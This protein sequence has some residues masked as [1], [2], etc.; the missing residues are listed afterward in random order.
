MAF[1]RLIAGAIVT[2]A[3]A[4][5]LSEPSARATTVFIDSA[6]SGCDQC[7]GGPASVPPGTTVS[8]LINP[9]QLSLGAGT[10]T[11]TDATTTGYYSAWNFSGGWV[12]SFVVVDDATHLI[13]KT[14]YTYNSVSGT[15]AEA[16]TDTTHPTY[17]GST[18]LGSGGAPNF[19]DTLV[20]S[21][22]T[23]L[24]FFTIDFYV[25]D[26]SGGVAINIAASSEIPEPATAAVLALPLLVGLR[27]VRQSRSGLNTV[28]DIA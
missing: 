27:R 19:M 13:L 16:A 24:D 1:L 21:A 7:S 6:V 8:G 25:P 3:I 4:S 12:W 14:D 5:L 22:P 23:L 20:L 18:Y 17:D 10:Y 2:M 15:Q 28:L 9:V 11:L 26:N